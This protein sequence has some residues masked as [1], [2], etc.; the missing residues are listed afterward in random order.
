MAEDR[1]ESRAH[2]W[3]ERLRASPTGPG[4]FKEAYAALGDLL[5]F[6]P[7]ERHL[8][9]GDLLKFNVLVVGKRISAVIDWGCALYGDFLYDLAWFCYWAPWYPAWQ[10]I[11]FAGEA[12]KHYDTIALEVPQF[13]ERLRACQI[14]TGLDAMAYTAF[15]QRWESLDETARRT[16]EVGQRS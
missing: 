1:P 14:H 2:G 11:D 13:A 4:P 3:R 12:A 6:C 7:E 15:K 10:G 9:H 16:L 5:P 8:V